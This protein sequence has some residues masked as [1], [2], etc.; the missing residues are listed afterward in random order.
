M[1][2]EALQVLLNENEYCRILGISNSKARQDRVNGRGCRFIK[3]GRS[4]KYHPE[5]IKNYLDS[6]V[7]NS[8]ITVATQS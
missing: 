2:N 8:T 3:I 6:R 1:S 5:D 7:H 4:V